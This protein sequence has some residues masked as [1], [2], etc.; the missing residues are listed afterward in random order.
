MQNSSPV[1]IGCQVHTV[2]YILLPVNR[3]SKRAYKPQT[4][5]RTKGQVAHACRVSCTGAQ[6]H[7]SANSGWSPRPR[8][9]SEHAILYK[10]ARLS[11]HEDG[12]LDHSLDQDLAFGQGQ[13]PTNIHSR[14]IKCTG[15]S[16]CALKLE[17]VRAG[18]HP[19]TRNVEIARAMWACTELATTG[20]LA[21]SNSES[22]AC[23]PLVK[24]VR[25]YVQRSDLSQMLMY[26]R[27][28]EHRIFSCG[29]RGTLE[30]HAPDT[31]H[32]LREEITRMLRHRL[33]LADLHTLIEA[34]RFRSPA[35]L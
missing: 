14:R 26:E 25:D 31:P 19:H 13:C 4:D 23:S 1:D 27:N 17:R 29:S 3:C 15:L 34:T 2:I 11:Q 10:S 30:H 22:G 5:T 16:L 7:A 28:C 20:E 6:A 12:R 24:P 8:D 21:R 18:R 35:T 9:I 32:L 33:G